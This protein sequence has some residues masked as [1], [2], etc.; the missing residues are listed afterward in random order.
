[1]KA[2]SYCKMQKI[3][4]VRQKASLFF[5]IVLTKSDKR[6]KINIGKVEEVR[7]CKMKKIYTDFIADIII[8]VAALAIAIIMLPPIGIGEKLL[9]L[10]V[11]LSIGIFMLPYQ[12][13]KM[14]RNY[15]KIFII[16]FIEVCITVILILDLIA[17]QFD[18][19]NINFEVCRVLGI[20][21]WIR[22]F[23]SL[24]CTYMAGFARRRSKYA[25]PIFILGILSITVGAIGF[26]HPFLSN[27]F[28]TWI[29][30]VLFMLIALAFGG[31]AF[32][33]APIK[34]KQK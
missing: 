3:T 26:A 6:V 24:L 34:P 15:G 32:L 10:F 1:M 12:I 27:T 16:T 25:L 14:K 20:A 13:F 31:L 4:G 33:Y 7:R 17:G 11:A 18:V 21:V 29:F 30:C 19:L 9:E 28:L 2:K 8:A 5:Y 23:C 22:A